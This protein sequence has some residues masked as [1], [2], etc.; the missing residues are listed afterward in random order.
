MSILPADDF[1]HKDI[2]S[3]VSG[4]TKFLKGLTKHNC[5]PKMMTGEKIQRGKTLEQEIK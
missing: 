2:F 3:K 5:G 1:E 4:K